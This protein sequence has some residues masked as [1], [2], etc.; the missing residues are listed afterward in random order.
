MHAC[1]SVGV[2]MTEMIAIIEQ[3]A[4]R[5]PMLHS[6]LMPL[7]K[8][9]K[10]YAL[11]LILYKDLF[12]VEV[13]VSG[14]EQL[15]CEMLKNIISK[16]MS[17]WFTSDSTDLQNPEAWIASPALIECRKELGGED[18]EKQAKLEKDRY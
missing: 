17:L 8:T 1:G 16:M 4:I 14:A 18:P 13:C 2:S 10:F 11:S 9:G 7:V 15:Y 12:D 6:N 3:Y 5:N